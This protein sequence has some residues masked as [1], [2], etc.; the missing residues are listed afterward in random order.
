M[1][2]ATVSYRVSTN[3]PVAFITIDDGYF[4]DPDADAFMQSTPVPVTQFLTYYAASSGQFPPP[5]SGPGLARRLPSEGTPRPPRP[6]RR[7][8][9]EG[10][11]R[12]RRLAWR[13]RHVQLA[14]PA[15]R[16]PYG[17][18]DDNTLQA[19]FNAGMPQ[20]VVWTHVFEQPSL[21]FTNEY[22]THRG[23]GPATTCACTTRTRPG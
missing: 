19:A 16:P 2:S 18:Y 5:T 10:D 11:G 15:F 20:L 3:S 8:P 6:V 1:S 22:G 4:T 14:A 21:V 23:C 9:A 7:R 17:Q 12:R 13:R